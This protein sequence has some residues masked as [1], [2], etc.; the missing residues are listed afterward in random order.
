MKAKTREWTEAEIQQL[1]DMRAKG[2]TYVDI[3]KQIKRS[4]CSAQRMGSM[5]GLTRE[6]SDQS[7]AAHRDAQ[8]LVPAVDRSKMSIT[9]LMLGD[10]PPGRSALDQGASA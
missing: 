10:P 4:V 6:F 8:T 3:S 5:L 9:A 1:K 2:M 7:A